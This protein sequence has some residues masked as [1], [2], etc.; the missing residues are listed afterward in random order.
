MKKIILG[1]LALFSLTNSYAQ[2]NVKICGTDEMEAY[3]MRTLPGYKQQVEAAQAAEITRNNANQLAKVMVD[4]NIIY[5][6]PVVFH[7]LHS[8][9]A[10]GTG[11]NLADSSFVR[12]IGNMNNDYSKN[13]PD[14]SQ[15]DPLFINIYKN[16]KIRFVLA[17]KD[18]LGNCTNGIVRHLDGNTFWAQNTAIFNY[19]YSTL[20]ANSWNPNKYMNI[21]IVTS[22]AGGEPGL[23]TVGYTYKPGSSPVPAADAIVYTASYLS[24]YEAVRSLSHEAGHWLS[25]SHTFGNANDAGKGA[26]G[27]DGVTD[28]PVTDG[29]LSTCRQVELFPTAPTVTI[30]KGNTDITKVAIDTISFTSI[31]DSLRTIVSVKTGTAIATKTLTSN[32]TKGEYSNLINLRQV[33]V[34]KGV[35]TFSVATTQSVSSANAVAVYL[36]LNANGVFDLTESIYSQTTTVMGSQVTTFTYNFTADKKILMRVIA[37]DGAIITDPAMLVNDGEY[38]DYYLNVGFA[39]CDTIRPNLENI[40]DYSRCPKM[41]TDG[42]RTKMRTSIETNTSR[43]NLVSAANLAYT[44]VD[45]LVATPCAPI[46]DFSFNTST[47]CMGQ[48]ITFKDVSYNGV[49]DTYNWNFTGG[50]PSSSSNSSEIVN[51]ATPGVYPVVLTVTNAQGQSTKTYSTIN[52]KWNSYDAEVLSNE[53]FENGLP[54]GWNIVNTDFGTPTWE[55][56]P[57]SSTLVA[58]AS[59]TACLGLLNASKTNVFNGAIDAIE[60]RQYNF[61]NVTAISL[62]LDFSAPAKATTTSTFTPSFELQYST[63]CGGTWNKITNVTFPL[64]GTMATQSAGI[65][66]APYFPV[67]GSVNSKW[68]TFTPN[69]ILINNALIGKRDVKLK[70]VYTVDKTTAQNVYI[71]NFNLSG[72]VG[73]NELENTIGL[74]IYPNPTSSTSTIEFTSPV[75]SNVE[76]LVTDITGR[77]VEKSNFKSNAGIASKY[78]VNKNSNLTAGMYVVSLILDGQKV[79]KKLIIN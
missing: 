69:T 5:T 8:G 40:M 16:L 1:A 25:L 20:A 4:T 63:N 38:E 56:V 33:N 36:D 76:V 44:G 72:V 79:T 52:V 70:I 53:D 13:G 74:S 75:N 64:D 54:Y 14:V 73:I 37:N 11:A 39:G 55:L 24:N 60:T 49:V 62:S 42:Q 34:K 51:Y 35:R 50:T 9:E 23:T 77:L 6:I 61:T 58:T 22:I 67:S 26:C 48:N 2:N 71:D 32:G 45:N 27:D 21:Y 57:Y 43:M 3:H 46:A 17:K 31:K 41:F 66:S 78:I 7:V 59:Q 15:I 47:T 30:P 29:Q 19:K 10:I 12:I 65:L 18:P 28:T 68:K